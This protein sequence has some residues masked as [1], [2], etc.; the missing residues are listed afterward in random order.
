MKQISTW[1]SWSMFCG[2]DAG[3]LKVPSGKGL[4]AKENETVEA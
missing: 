2:E 4:G 3:A 1:H